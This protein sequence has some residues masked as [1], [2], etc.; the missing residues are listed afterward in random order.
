MT[1]QDYEFFT[2]VEEAEGFGRKVIYPPKPI[3]KPKDEII[4]VE[5]KL[6]HKNTGL[7]DLAV[8]LLFSVLIIAIT[9]LMIVKEVSKT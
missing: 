6:T 5:I 3:P 2:P 7:G 1:K 8:A 9:T 4:R